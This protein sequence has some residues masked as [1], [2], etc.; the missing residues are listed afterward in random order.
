MGGQ[1]H[2][3]GDVDTQGGV[4]PQLREDIMLSFA[5]DLGITAI[6]GD[7]MKFLNRVLVNA[8]GEGMARRKSS[9]G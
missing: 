1:P 9:T 6:G 3:R 2:L 8:L 7:G 5:S 4:T